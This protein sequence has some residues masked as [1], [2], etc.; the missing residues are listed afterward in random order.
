MTVPYSPSKVQPTKGLG[1]RR[2][3]PCSYARYAPLCTLYSLQ[4]SV[5]YT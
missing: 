2:L 4:Y 5:Q 1:A 3:P